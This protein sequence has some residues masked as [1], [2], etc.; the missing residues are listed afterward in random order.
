MSYVIYTLTGSHT[1]RREQLK[2]N[3]VMRALGSAL[4]SF[5]TNANIVVVLCNGVVD[6]YDPMHIM[7]FK[8]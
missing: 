4:K 3:D 7:N 1:Q 2:K 5:T 6:S 8:T